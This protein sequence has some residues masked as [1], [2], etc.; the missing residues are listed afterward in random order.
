[1]NYSSIVG[2]GGYLPS[3]IV[4]NQELAASVDTNDEWISSRTGIRQRHLAADDDN[5]ESMA[6]HAG[7]RALQA[8]NMDAA[9]IDMIIVATSTP[10]KVFPSVACMVQHKLG[11]SGAAAFDVQAACSG[12]IYAVDIADKYIRSGN[13]QRILV[14]GSE[15]MSRIVDWSDRNTCVLFGD[16]AGA[17]VMCATSRPGISYSKLRADGSYNE[18]LYT[19]GGAGSAGSEPSYLRMDGRQ[20]FR[21][22]IELAAQ[23]L[24]EAMQATGLGVEDVDWLVLHQANIRIMKQ[25]AQKVGIAE[26]KLICTVGQHGNTSAASIPLALNEGFSK[27]M[28]KPGHN[29]LLSGFGGGF[30]WGTTALHYHGNNLA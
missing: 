21:L 7:L 14:I 6:C 5:T 11:I 22:A 13:C 19:P 4:S 30:T 17:V 27:D 10:E 26:N 2:F 3:K 8:A 12:F 25:I 9:D 24:L 28:I 1:M 23:D 16:G 20:V 29:L 15:C 18:L